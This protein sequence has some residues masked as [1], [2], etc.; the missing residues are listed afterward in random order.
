[1]NP[2]G[3]CGVTGLHACLGSI[4]APLTD[5]QRAELEM[6]LQQAIKEVRQLRAAPTIDTIRTV[7]DP[8]LEENYFQ[9]S[10]LEL[11]RE[12]QLLYEFLNEVSNNAEDI[13]P[14]QELDWESLTVGWAVAKGIPTEEA[15][16]FAIRV[17][18][19]SS[20]A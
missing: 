8:Y 18:Y 17:R 1:M 6:N 20:L 12:Y 9:D 13:D 19:R 2:C 11:E 10:Q 15:R 3:R 7:V 14:D 4:P 16:S 5:E